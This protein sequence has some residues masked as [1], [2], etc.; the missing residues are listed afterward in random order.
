MNIAL[1]IYY[2][3]QI[4]S[5]EEREKLWLNKLDK[6]ERWICGE[7]VDIS[8]GEESYYSLLEYHRRRNKQLGYGDNRV[9][10]DRKRYEH[11]RRLIK[12]NE[13]RVNKEKQQE[14]KL[15][16]EQKKREKAIRLMK[17][18]AKIIKGIK[19]ALE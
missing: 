12:Q 4:Y 15:L 16:R 2:R 5:E 11:E 6:Q 3:N 13:R 17:R 7:R 9:N 14:R 1:P 8:K 18:C 10:W 19:K